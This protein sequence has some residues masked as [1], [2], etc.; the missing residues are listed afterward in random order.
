MIGQV[1]VSCDVLIDEAS[2]AVSDERR[3]WRALLV[4]AA[5]FEHRRVLLAA[6]GT[7]LIC[8]K[9]LRAGRLLMMKMWRRDERQ[10]NE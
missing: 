3:R 6:R 7:R 5:K 8:K 10:M 4:G 2:E 9:R 1:H